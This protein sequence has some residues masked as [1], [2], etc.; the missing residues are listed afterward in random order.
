MASF[1]R[2][3]STSRDAKLMRASTSSCSV[4]RAETKSSLETE[5]YEN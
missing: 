3:S 4:S 2:P 1:S 5:E